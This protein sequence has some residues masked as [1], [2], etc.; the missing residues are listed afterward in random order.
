VGGVQWIEYWW[1]EVIALDVARIA[2]QS[3]VIPGE[4]EASMLK[5]AID[6]VKDE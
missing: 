2:G 6:I 4:G 3:A 1:V 5:T